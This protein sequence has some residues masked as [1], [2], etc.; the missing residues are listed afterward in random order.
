MNM[1][2]LDY[3]LEIPFAENTGRRCVPACA[4]MVANYLMPELKISKEGA[5][6][7]SGFSDDRATW[8]T[9]HLLS[10]ADMGLQVGWIQ[11]ED[12][13]AFA[14]SPEVY[15]QSQFRSISGELNEQA[16]DNF[17]RTN[18]ITLEASRIRS[19]LQRDLAFEKRRATPEDI[20][21]RMIGG[22]VVRLEVNGK[23]LADRTGFVNHAV[24]VSG[25]NDSVVRLENPD[26]KHG[27]KPKQL[28]SWDDLEDA[29]PEERALQY[30][31]R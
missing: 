11:D 18:D 13:A 8:A 23:K 25:F 5:E 3:E 17:L 19:Y 7:L 24:I 1:P 14:A 15:I 31:R 10:L 2:K 22:Y 30:Y 16:Y 26:G 12:I 9:Q 29:W 28:V 20:T 21:Q 6:K 4:E 27:S